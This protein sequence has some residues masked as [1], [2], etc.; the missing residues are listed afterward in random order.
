MAMTIKQLRN[1]SE[2]DLINEHDHPARYLSPGVSY[3]LDELR[4]RDTAR[5]SAPAMS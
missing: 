1:D 2:D 5:A 3:Y 4:R